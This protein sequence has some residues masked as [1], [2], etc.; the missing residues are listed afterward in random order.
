MSAI[1]RGSRL[2]FL[3]VQGGNSMPLTI[4]FSSPGN[5]TIDDDGIRGNG[6]SVVRDGSGA[7]LFSFSHPADSITFIADTPG[8][9]LTFNVAD[10]FGSANVFVGDLSSPA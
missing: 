1:A 4:F 3:R 5:Y 10:S 7:I 9:N 8:V 6:T 2:R